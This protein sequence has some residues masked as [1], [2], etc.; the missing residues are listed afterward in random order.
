MPFSFLKLLYQHSQLH[1]ESVVLSVLCQVH[2]G[3]RK[4]FNSKVAAPV[5]LR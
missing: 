3:V 5:D 1:K 2:F 4:I